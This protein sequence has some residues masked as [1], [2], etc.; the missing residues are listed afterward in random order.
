MLGQNSGVF[1]QLLIDEPFG[2]ALR[3]EVAH[4]LIFTRCTGHP[5]LLDLLE[6]RPLGLFARPDWP[7]PAV[8]MPELQVLLP[9][10]GEGAFSY[11]GPRLHH[12]PLTAC[13]RRVFQLL[14]LGLSSREICER[15]GSSLHTVNT[16]VRHIYEKYG[17]CSR[18]EAVQQYWGK[19]E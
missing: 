7:E 2:T 9:R 19:P 17:V 16:H 4:R 18:A 14:A 10:R 6:R 8:L 11:L 13:E 5:Y 1:A 15:T 12:S 3:G